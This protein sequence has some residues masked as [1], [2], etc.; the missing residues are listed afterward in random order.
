MP[1]AADDVKT[2]QELQ[3]VYEGKFEY[4]LAM[5]KVNKNVD[6]IKAISL[7][8]EFVTSEHQD[9]RQVMYAELMILGHRP[10]F[11]DNSRS[12]GC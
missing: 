11:Q 1:S 10:S 7:F 6:I 5:K 4:Y 3:R 2:V 12:D 9:I 8:E